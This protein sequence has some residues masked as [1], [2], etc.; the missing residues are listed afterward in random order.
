MGLKMSGAPTEAEILAGMHKA[1]GSLEGDKKKSSG[2]AEASEKAPVE[3]KPD[4][5]RLRSI[6]DRIVRLEEEKKG[7]S[8]D[9]K[10][11]YAE[12]KSGG[13]SKKALRL[14]IKE[15]MEDADAR[16]SREAAE[17]ERDNMRA[18]LGELAS[19]PLGEFA[20]RGKH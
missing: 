7:L 18:A 14:Y 20:T 10:E 17:L 4:I 1:V 9:I 8:E 3:T 6:V 12:A 19:T 15:E 5:E 16:E 2:K 11:I 13:Y